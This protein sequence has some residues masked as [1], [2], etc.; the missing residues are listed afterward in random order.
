MSEILV[1]PSGHHREFLKEGETAVELEA[2][3][4]PNTD[5]RVFCLPYWP[6]GIQMYKAW[7]AVPEHLVKKIELK[8]TV[9]VE[10]DEVVPFSG[11]GAIL[12]D[13]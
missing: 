6:G 11:M 2:L 7:V 10:G 3:Q 9:I 4:Q 8:R 5:F 1:L 12:T 13:F